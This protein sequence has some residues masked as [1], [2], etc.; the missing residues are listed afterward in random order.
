MK[1]RRT[2]TP[3]AKKNKSK[4]KAPPRINVPEAS[5]DDVLAAADSSLAGLNVEQAIQL[6][7]KAASLLRAGRTGSLETRERQLISVLE[8]LAEC[9]VAMEDQTGALQ[10]FKEAITLVEQE[11]DKTKLYYYETRCNLYLYVGQ[12]CSDEQALDAYQQGISSLES[13][14]KFVQDAEK[15][16]MADDTNLHSKVLAEMRQKL[17]GAY[18]TIAELYLTDLCYEDNA[19]AECESNLQKALQIKDVDG[20]P[21]VDALQTVASLRL[22][23]EGRRHEAIPYILQTYEKMKTGCDALASLV[24]LTE[25]QLKEDDDDSEE[26]QQQQQAVELKEV[27]EAENLPEFEFRCQTAKLLLECADFLKESANGE[28]KKQEQEQHCV[29]AAI[30][31]LGS[32]LAQDDEVVEIWFLTGC[33]FCAKTNPPAP[34][35]ARYYLDRTMEML[36]DIQKSLK[37]E[38][39]CADDEEQD[40]IQEQLAE[41][42]TQIEDVQEK[43]DGLGEEGKEEPETMEE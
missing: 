37:Q 42:T 34:D 12:L 36:L 7:S 14:V 8:K 17:S 15:D 19:E 18:C 43:L 39:E 41:N 1:S 28:Q 31:V 38:E 32:L 27:D 5:V 9:K 3:N 26:Q 2:T 33:A 10:D 24:G 16:E 20:Q 25:K 6:Y 13:C 22:S 23:Q 30:S 29:S 40:D 21:A 11:D 35:S 4:K